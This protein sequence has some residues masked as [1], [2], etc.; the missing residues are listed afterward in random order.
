MIQIEGLQASE[1]FSEL[2]TQVEDGESIVIC[3]NKLPVAQLVPMP[4]N[5]SK[6]TAGTSGANEKIMRQFG[7]AKDKIKMSADFDAP[8]DDFK[9][10][11]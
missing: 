4:Q 3:R 5:E 2:L 11:S 6:T 9:K 10:Y 8:L 7:S 1:H